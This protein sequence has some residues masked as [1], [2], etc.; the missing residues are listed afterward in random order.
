MKEQLHKSIFKISGK[1]NGLGIIRWCYS[2]INFV[3]SIM[4]LYYFL[5][6][7]LLVINNIFTSEIISLGYLNSL[8]KNKWDIEE[9]RNKTV[10]CD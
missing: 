6:L 2:I 9:T 4:V 1:A 7:Y 5:R 3:E 8:E 10:D